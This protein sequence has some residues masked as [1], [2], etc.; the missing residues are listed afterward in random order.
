M[1]II[2]IIG[3]IITVRVKFI[4]IN[5]GKFMKYIKQFISFLRNK[6]GV[7][8]L[9]NKLSNLNYIDRIRAFKKINKKD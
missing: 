5:L 6:I 4:K 3:L 9:K 8:K 7:C 2:F 1:C